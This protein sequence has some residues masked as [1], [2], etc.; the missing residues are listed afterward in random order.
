[1]KVLNA[2]LLLLLLPFSL[3]AQP[4]SSSNKVTYA[5][6]NESST[7]S[8]EG[9]STIGSWDAVVEVVEGEFMVDIESLTSG[10][11]LSN[12]FEL[13]GFSVPVG[14][15]DSD[16]RRMN[17]NISKYLKEDDYPAITFTLNRAEV[18]DTSNAGYEVFVNGNISAA[19]E[20]H[21]VSFTSSVTM[22]ENG[23][24]TINGEQ[25]LLFSHF[26]IDRPSAVFGTIK[27]DEEIQILYNLV[28]TSR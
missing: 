22:D 5:I 25:Q 13:S 18:T 26:N 9:G 6:D 11:N 16:S 10:E 27:A 4:A 3:I 19:G 17:K 7:M 12:V 21:E 8:I 1:M 23:N 15:I 2:L 28:L 20:D 14:N 24:L